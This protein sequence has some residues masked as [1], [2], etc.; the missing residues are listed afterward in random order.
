[1]KMLIL[2][3]GLGVL[4]GAPLASLEAIAFDSRQI[5]L[6]DFRADEMYIQ[7]PATREDVEAGALV[8]KNPSYHFLP[9]IAFEDTHILRFRNGEEVVRETLEDGT[10]AQALI[11]GVYDH[12][13][14]SEVSGLSRVCRALG[15]SEVRSVL[16]KEAALSAREARI[17]ERKVS[18]LDVQ[19]A[20]FRFDEKGAIWVHIN[21][22]DWI[23]RDDDGYV[24]GSAAH[25]PKLD[26]RGSGA[27]YAYEGY[28]LT[29]KDRRVVTELVCSPRSPTKPV[30]FGKA[31][32]TIKDSY[33]FYSRDRI[34]RAPASLAA[35]QAR[36]GEAACANLSD[37]Y[38]LKTALSDRLTR[39]QKQVE[40]FLSVSSDPQTAV[41]AEGN[42]HVFTRNYDF[43]ELGIAWKDEE[44]GVV[45][46]DAL[47][48]SLGNVR[49]DIQYSDASDYC[50]RL[51]V[52]LPTYQDFDVLRKKLTKKTGRTFFKSQIL[53]GLSGQRFW[54]SSPLNAAAARRGDDWQ[55]NSLPAWFFSEGD[56]G[57]ATDIQMSVRCAVRTKL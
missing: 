36:D 20:A 40:E 42:Q 46:G 8:V 7:D 25:S 1:M 47:R 35:T 27:V 38:Q 53:P 14:T 6:K 52:H 51:H 29:R 12:V 31:P 18:R 45:W 37:C 2:R 23:D 39:V 32:L 48:D 30:N 16:S 49:R 26:H 41:D 13:T 57:S 50:H 11:G 15:Y 24:F 43:L 28:I 21:N 56:F 44:T 22:A 9:L 19:P 55:P 54:V 3:A 5:D 10:D 4:L 34:W 17:V 33:G